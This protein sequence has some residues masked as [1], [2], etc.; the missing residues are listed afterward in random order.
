MVSDR[1]NVLI[2]I[3]SKNLEFV[4]WLIDLL[5]K[6]RHLVALCSNK[7]EDHKFL[8]LRDNQCNDPPKSLFGSFLSS[9]N[10]E[11]CARPELTQH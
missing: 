5:A 10:F 2:W 7:V 3:L 4:R 9:A 1:V 8:G 11:D 6:D